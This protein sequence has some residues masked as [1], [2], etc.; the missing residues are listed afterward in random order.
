LTQRGC[1]ARQ[2]HGGQQHDH[3]A[4][5]STRHE[6]QNSRHGFP[7]FRHRPIAANFKHATKHT[8]NSKG[9]KRKFGT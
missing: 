3:R 1:A 8:R 2:E 5:Q 9:S 7:C 4:L 6:K